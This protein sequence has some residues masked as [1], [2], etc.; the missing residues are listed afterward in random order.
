M[1]AFHTS[2]SSILTDFAS[3]LHLVIV[4]IRLSKYVCSV[5]KPHS[6]ILYYKWRAKITA[7]ILYTFL[8]LNHVLERMEYKIKSFITTHFMYT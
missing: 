1:Y 4:I 8:I 7:E 6:L 5:T 3:N 2:Y